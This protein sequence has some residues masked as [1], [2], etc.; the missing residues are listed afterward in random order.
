VF[1]SLCVCVCRSRRQGEPGLH[2]L[3]GAIGPPG[4]GIPGAKVRPPPAQ[5][6]ARPEHS[7]HRHRSHGDLPLTGSGL[8]PGGSGSKRPSWTRTKFLYRIIKTCIFNTLD[9]DGGY[10]CCRMIY[11]QRSTHH[12]SKLFCLYVCPPPFVR[13]QDLFLAY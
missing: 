13:S 2:G 11:H 10:A 5:H 12:R 1:E 4:R 9:Q 6:T 8:L 7:C 3:A